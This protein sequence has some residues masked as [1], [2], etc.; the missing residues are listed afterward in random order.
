MSTPSGFFTDKNR[1]I[2][3]ITPSITS[4]FG[5]TLSD[6]ENAA[7]RDLLRRQ[8]VAKN[9]RR[10]VKAGVDPHSIGRDSLNPYIEATRTPQLNTFD[11]P[12]TWDEVDDWIK[13]KATEYG[14]RNRFLSSD[15]YRQTFPHIEKLRQEEIGDIRSRYEKSMEEVGAKYGDKVEYSVGTPFGQIY[16]WKGI[17]IRDKNDL[18]KVKVIETN[19]PG[20]KRLR[21]WHKG[22]TR[23]LLPLPDKCPNCGSKRKQSNDLNSIA[24]CYDCGFILRN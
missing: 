20:A 11:M 19:E 5:S 9:Q 17:I 7:R 2:R 8:E 23:I 16:Y 13:R 4:Y 6:V 12:Q 15:E 24:T 10:I 14:G 1:K 3:P 21:N 18:P 22:Y